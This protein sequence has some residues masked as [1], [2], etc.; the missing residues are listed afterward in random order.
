MQKYELLLVLPGTFDEKEAET[1]ADKI[2]AIVNEF[3]SEAVLT[4]LG[5][6]RLAY[7][8]KQIRYGYFYTIIFQAEAEKIKDL[9]NKMNLDKNILRAFITKYNEN[10]SQAQKISYFNAETKEESEE[11]PMEEVKIA[12]PI[13]N[14]EEAKPRTEQSSSVGE[15]PMDMKDI[16]KK[17][18]EILAD[19]NLMTKV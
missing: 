1:E 13:K 19:D 18:D 17:L 10:L 5:K 9:K 7:P 15:K 12:E 2:L 14:E 16:D 11:G 4:T 6:N 3:G 8:I